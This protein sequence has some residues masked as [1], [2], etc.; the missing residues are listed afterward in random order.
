MATHSPHQGTCSLPATVQFLAFALISWLISI[1]TLRATTGGPDNFGYTF[2]DSMEHNGP[3]FQWIDITA[4]G[5]EVI[6]QGDD[7]ASTSNVDGIGA[8]VTLTFPFTFHGVTYESLSPTSNGYLS[9]DTVEKGQDASNDSTLPTPPSDGIG[10]RLY[11]FH[12]D[13]TLDSSNGKVYYQYLDHSGHPH[14]DCGVSVFSWVDLR[15]AGGSALPLNFQALLFDNGDILY[16]YNTSGLS[17]GTSVTVGIQNEAGSD[18][19][20]YGANTAGFITNNLAV[21]FE[22]PILTVTTADDELDTPAGANLSLREAI[23]DIPQGGKIEVASNIRS[24]DLSEGD[25]A[26]T[27]TISNKSLSIDGSNSDGKLCLTGDKSFRIMTTTDVKLVLV[28]VCIR[29]GYNPLVGGGL[30]SESYDDHFRLCH[31]DFVG[32]ESEGSA[33]AFRLLG[34]A[35]LFRCRFQGN[36]AYG[37][38]AGMSGFKNPANAGTGTVVLDECEFA[39]NRG[40]GR[41][42]GAYFVNYDSVHVRG[43][44]FFDNHQA[45]TTAE[46]G[47]LNIRSNHTEVVNCT[48]TRNTYGALSVGSSS[49]NFTRIAH[50]T[51]T[52]NSGAFT[53]AVEA[54][55]SA[56]SEFH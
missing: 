40:F 20:L 43:C 50:C 11:V 34:E 38:G 14:S 3:A 13:L 24:I 6:S 42:I 37:N 41:G 49:S 48:F 44:S 1:N 9:T 19:L 2:I 39:C 30:R 47:A 36:Q 33:G 15:F 4:T 32:N 52:D 29:G 27:L 7:T 5:Q 31:V 25:P 56:I 12:D 26:T 16:Q 23:R 17:F 46:F 35:R 54:W 22:P 51:F 18:G 55:G 45:S 28:D 10:A 8:T 21:L 53:S